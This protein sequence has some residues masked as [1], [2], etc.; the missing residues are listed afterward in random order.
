[1]SLMKVICKI[2][3]LAAVAGL[4][5]GC[6]SAPA[7]APVAADPTVLRVG[8]SA[9]TPPMVFKEGG[10]IVGV[11]R[12]LAEALGRELG[13]RVVF[14]EE[15]FENLI[16]SLCENRIDII[17]SSMS[18]TPARSHRL[19]FTEPYLR[20]GQLALTRSADR[21]SYLMNL[22][23]YAKHGIGVKPATTAD[24]LVQQE[25]PQVKRRYYRD[26]QAAAEALAKQDID[27]FIGDAPFI[28]YLAGLYE[29]KGVVVTPMV[30]SQEDLA[31]G[32]R[33]SDTALLEAA[34]RLLQKAR[35]SGEL[36]R[37]FSK[38]MPGF[39]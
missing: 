3:W 23:A 5:A 7:P 18:I 21:Y 22:T 35:A 38:W 9:N 33:R 10:Q 19:A 36:N 17:M 26:G 16:D 14:V 8:V 34:N 29:T 24:L 27:L 13:R 20:V 11:E 25:F 2:F 4:I 12:D 31:W 39:Q 32:L 15:K 37:V 6:A 28:W 30:L 1:M